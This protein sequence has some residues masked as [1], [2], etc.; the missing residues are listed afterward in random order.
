MY[1]D[2]KK[3][4]LSKEIM[5]DRYGSKEEFDK[6]CKAQFEGEDNQKAC[7]YIN[8]ITRNQKMRKGS[9]AVSKKDSVTIKES[10]LQ[11]GTWEYWEEHCS[12]K[13][14]QLDGRMVSVSERGGNTS[15]EKSFDL[16]TK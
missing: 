4:L 13:S 2:N 5:A 11:K 3:L 12:T 9:T 1:F 10:Q 6:L 15:K 16:G 7:A 14:F 8:S